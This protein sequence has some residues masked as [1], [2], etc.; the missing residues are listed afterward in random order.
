MA[1]LLATSVFDRA[2][3]AI[4]GVFALAAGSFAA[5]FDNRDTETKI[6]AR[7][8]AVEPPQLWRVDAL[9][10]TGEV[11]ASV[12]VCADT[13][14]R[15]TF[16]R[17]RAEVNGEICKDTTEPVMRENGWALRC[18]AH[19]WPFAVSATTVGDPQQDFRLNFGLTQLYYVPTPN[20]PPAMQVRQSR[21]FRRVGDC[22]YGWRIGDQARPGHKPW[23]T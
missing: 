19:G 8:Q 12:F 11:K 14:L 10:E 17:T 13:A 6:L 16:V 5:S 15:E 1:V 21:R 18:Q 20:D 23:R 7:Q 9:T 22:P 3:L 4:A 2:V